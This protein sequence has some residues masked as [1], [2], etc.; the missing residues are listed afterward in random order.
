MCAMMALSKSF[1]T[2]ENVIRGETWCGP[3]PKLPSMPAA[4]PYTETRKWDGRGAVVAP[5]NAKS[6][7]ASVVDTEEGCVL[8]AV[9]SG[10]ALANPE[11]TSTLSIAIR[12]RG[13]IFRFLL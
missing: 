1:Q 4:K 2:S 13:D 8:A 10:L 6:G 9:V 5:L 7:G 3:K 12:W 11:Q